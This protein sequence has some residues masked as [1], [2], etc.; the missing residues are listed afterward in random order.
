MFGRKLGR[1]A[2]LVFALVVAF[3]GIAGLDAHPSESGAVQTTNG[4]VEWD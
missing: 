1:F 4:I 3:G 2:G